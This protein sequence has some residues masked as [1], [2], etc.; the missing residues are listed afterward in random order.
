MQVVIALYKENVS[1]IRKIPD[2][3]D[4]VVYTKQIDFPRYIKNIK[5]IPLENIG[6]ESH[7]YFYHICEN[8]DR[9][10]DITLFLQGRPFDHAPKIMSLLSC[11]H[12]PINNGFFCIGNRQFSLD[13]IDMKLRNI[14][15]H[16]SDDHFSRLKET[17][18]LM[19]VF[20]NQ[21]HDDPLPK[22]V[23]MSIGNQ[24]GITSDK[25]RD[26]P[27][28]VY[29]RVFEMHKEHFVAPWVMEKILPEVFEKDLNDRGCI[30]RKKCSVFI[31][32]YAIV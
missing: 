17:S 10:H 30:K 31:P 24:F 9:L 26:F 19:P 25:I 20:W 15:Y 21:F 3:W 8:Y 12:I 6:R 13:L 1:W 22:K 16:A 14:L 23:H 28:E 4:I 29:R 32:K 27:I 2:H 18:E 7:T 11:K 5:F